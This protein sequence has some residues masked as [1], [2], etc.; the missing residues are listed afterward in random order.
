ML[1]RRKR[2]AEMAIR[3]SRR[4]YAGMYGPTTGDRVRLADTELFI[5]VEKDHTV[6]GEEVKF[7]GGKVIR[8]GM[9]QSQVTR[10]GGSVDTV[11]T[12]ALVLE[13]DRYLQGRHRPARRAH[14][15]HRQGRQ[16]GH[17]A[18]R[19][20]HHRPQHRDHR[21]RG[22]NPHGRRHRQ[23]HPF[24]LPT[25]DRG[26]ALRRRHHHARRRHGSCPWNAGDDLHSAPGMSAGC[27]RRWK[28]SR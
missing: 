4:A 27:C 25:A 10:A 5:R 16:S 28:P 18:R 24:H 22:P 11:I 19:H 2:S 12:N 26:G 20:H 15:R 21:R 17:P 9:G 1:R 3:I 6:Y 13:L 8:D 14:R 7:G 23:P